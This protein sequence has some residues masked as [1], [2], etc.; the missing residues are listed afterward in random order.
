[1]L[2]DK[3]YPEVKEFPKQEWGDYV[4]WEGEGEKEDWEG[5][6]NEVEEEG[7]Q[8]GWD[9]EGKGHGKTFDD[10]NP[11]YL[12]SAG[13]KDPKYQLWFWYAD[14]DRPLWEKE[15]D[16][17]EGWR[18]PDWV[19]DDDG[20]GYVIV[21]TDEYGKGYVII[22]TDEKGKG[23]VIIITVLVIISNR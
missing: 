22:I 6:E 16:G 1:M 11:G 2:A 13:R 10:V 4:D 14:S 17:G 21:I 8:G 15:E 19:E 23:Y 18:A 12:G 7:G 3:V 5:E 9:K 20:K